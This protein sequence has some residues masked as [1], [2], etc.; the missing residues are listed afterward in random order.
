MKSVFSVFEEG[1]RKESGCGVR[2]SST[3]INAMI[4]FRYSVNG[5]VE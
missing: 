1:I 4:K 3:G 2:P 5:L